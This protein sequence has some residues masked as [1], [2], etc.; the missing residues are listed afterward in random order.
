MREASSPDDPEVKKIERTD[1]LGFKGYCWK[2]SLNDGWL[3]VFERE[4]VPSDPAEDNFYDY[5]HQCVEH[6]IIIMKD[7]TGRIYIKAPSFFPPDDVDEKGAADLPKNASV[8]DVINAENTPS[9]TVSGW[10]F[11]EVK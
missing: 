1:A 8:S 10:N 5:L 7:N 6:R 9:K 4:Y 3:M 11:W 2:V